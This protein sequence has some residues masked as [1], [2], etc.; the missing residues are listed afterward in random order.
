MVRVASA[1]GGIGAAWGAVAP[2]WRIM[3]LLPG[4]SLPLTLA[5]AAG[6]GLGVLLPLANTFATGT[7]VGAVPAAIRDGP[8][9]SAARAA[10]VALVEVGVLFVLIRLLGTVRSTLALSLGRRLDAHLRERV[11]VALNR[12]TGVAHLE[13]PSVHDLMERA[14]DVSGSR[15]SAGTTVEPLANAAAGWLQAA[16]ATLILAG[17]NVALALGWFATCAVAAQVL[18]REFLRSLELFYSQTSALR[19]ANY[20]RQLGLDGGS[21]KEVRIWGMLGWLIDRFTQEAM[22]VLVPDWA[23][24]SRGNRA[25]G[26]ASLAIAAVQ[27]A[28][29]AA[30]GVAAAQGQ[31]TL[32]DL[33]VYVGA[34]LTLGVL[35]LPRRDALPL[36][37]GTA[38]LP[39]VLALERS[40]TDAAAVAGRPTSGAGN[41]ASAEI[42]GTA[43]VRRRSVPT[44]APRLGIRFEGVSFRYSGRDVDPSAGSGQAVLQD[45][46]LFIPAG[47]SLAIVGENGAGKTTLV[48]LIARLYDPAAGRITVDGVDLREFDARDWQRRVSAIFQDFVRFALPARD[49]VGFGAIEQIDNQPALVEAVRKAG[50]LEVIEALP[51]GWDT[52]L[53]R[54]FA[55]GAD[56][57]GGQWQRIA[58]ARALFAVSGGAHVLILDEPTANLDVRAEAALYERFLDITQGLT[59][60]LISHRFSTVRRADRIV[61]LE[62]GRIVEDGTHDELLAAGGRYAH[63]FTL[64]AQ[65]FV[66]GEAARNN[67]EPEPAH[68]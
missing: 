19:R 20:L 14:L 62:D 54:Q 31:I 65:R 55:G 58:L 15:W 63:M 32:R 67:A 17:F 51:R 36:A 57:S 40:T 53:S 26:L 42:Q 27:F 16:G 68:G 34:I 30:V 8:A 37:Y 64:Q 21:A 4:V 48:K 6:I 13:D 43:A 50:A 44:E 56:L 24:R 59:T 61:V 3:R 22:R 11:M 35:H 66:D 12:P 5:L 47:R 39:S 2:Y 28:V 45:L 7:L 1:S 9:S 10:M 33:T 25:H 52:V 60:I 46:D 38:T 41:G 29:L 18:R 23:A 49:N